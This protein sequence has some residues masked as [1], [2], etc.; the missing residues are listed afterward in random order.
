MANAH[1]ASLDNTVCTCFGLQA[2]FN[3]YGVKNVTEFKN[4]IHFAQFQIFFT[5]NNEI[6]ILN[7]Y[8]YKYNKLTAL[9]KLLK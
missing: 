4:I 1:D 2:D 7:I 5:L 6:N 8:Y 9:K 3:I